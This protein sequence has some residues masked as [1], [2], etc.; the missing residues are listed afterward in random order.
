MIGLKVFT[1]QGVSRRRGNHGGHI[2][3]LKAHVADQPV[4]QGMGGAGKLC[5]AHMGVSAVER[6]A[7]TLAG[8]GHAQ[9]TAQQL[10]HG[11]GAGEFLQAAQHI[12]KRAVPALAQRLHGDDVAHR[13]MARCQVDIVQP[14]RGAGGHGNLVLGQLQFID[15]VAAQCFGRH[16]VAHVLCLKQHD[17]AHVA[18]ALGFVFQ[19]FG[20]QLALRLHGPQHGGGPALGVLGQDDGQFDHVLACQLLRADVVEH[21]GLVRHRCGGQ[22]QDERWVEPLQGGEAFVGFG[23]VRL[24]DDDQGPVQRQPVGQA[25]ARLA[26]KALQHAGAVAG[27]V[28]CRHQGIR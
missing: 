19:C 10:L 25:P 28:F 3:R 15:E 8:V 22:F 5:C 17:G 18:V 6:L 21:I 27:S 13:A 23:V 2:Q 20:L 11:R 7:A 1:P 26:D 12:G 16:L 24:I 14:A 9:H 4:G